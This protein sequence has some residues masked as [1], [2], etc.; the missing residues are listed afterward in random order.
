MP[1]LV[2][3]PKYRDYSLTGPEGKLAIKKGTRNHRTKVCVVLLL[4]LFPPF[5]KPSRN[6]LFFFHY[7][8]HPNAR[9]SL[10]Y[11]SAGL[12]S[13][14]WYTPYIERKTLRRLMQRDDYHASRDTVVLFILI[15]SFGYVKTYT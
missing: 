6:P 9:C 14:T 12:A 2:D 1:P 11:H 13:A 7:L 15:F 10:R 4:F 5:F 8:P 3:P